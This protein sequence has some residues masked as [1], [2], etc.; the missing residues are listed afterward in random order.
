M[1]THFLN[2]SVLSLG[3]KVNTR[4]MSYSQPDMGSIFH[5]KNQWNVLVIGNYFVNTM[6]IIK[7]KYFYS[8]R[9][10]EELWWIYSCLQTPPRENWFQY[11]R[12]VYATA[13]NFPC[14]ITLVGSI[15]TNLLRYM[16]IV[17]YT[18]ILYTEHVTSTYSTYQRR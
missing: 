5:I 18:T 4:R 2:C 6:K 15:L 8:P 11:V 7:I 10:L 16:C 1:C 3:C 9:I 14:I 17:M 12:R 13:N